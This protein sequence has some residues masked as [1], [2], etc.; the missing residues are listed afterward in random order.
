MRLLRVGGPCTG[1]RCCVPQ[2]ARAANP[3]GAPPTRPHSDSQAG[4]RPVS[5]PRYNGNGPLSLPLPVDPTRPPSEDGLPLFLARQRPSTALPRP[6]PRIDMGHGARGTGHGDGDGICLWRGK[7]PFGGGTGHKTLPSTQTCHSVVPHRVQNTS[8]GLSCS[9]SPG[10][11]AGSGHGRGN[12]GRERG[13]R[14]H[15]C[16]GGGLRHHR[17]RN[18]IQNHNKKLFVTLTDSAPWFAT[19]VVNIRRGFLPLPLLLLPL[20]MWHWSKTG[21]VHGWLSVS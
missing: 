18:R 15:G 6:N 17:G 8:N 21:R 20:Y 4:G 7:R 5:D 11:G 9:V 12:R 1:L 3:C 2:A 16:D 13:T 19:L 14:G 10:R